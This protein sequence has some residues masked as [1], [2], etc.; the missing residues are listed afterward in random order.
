MFYIIVILK[1]LRILLLVKNKK[2][3][4]CQGILLLVKICIIN[5][6][7]EICMRTVRSENIVAGKNLHNKITHTNLYV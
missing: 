1:Y 6:L 4:F 5:L 7:I 3:Y 2:Y